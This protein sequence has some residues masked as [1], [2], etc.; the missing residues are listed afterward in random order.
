[1][2]QGM[3]IWNKIFVTVAY[4][5]AL[6]CSGCNNWLSV[7]PKAEVKYEDLFRSR[8]GFKD[9]LTGVYT[10]MCAEAA[11]GTNLTYG[12]VDAMGQ[13]Y[14]LERSRTNKFY[15]FTRWEYD[16][17]ANKQMIQESWDKMYNAIVNI[18]ILIQGLDEFSGVLK[19][20]EA[21]IYRGEALGLRAMLHFDLL[22]LFGES[23]VAGA[24]S[25]A[26][27]YMDKASTKVFPLGTTQEVLKRILTD[28]EESAKLLE[29]DP[30]HTGSEEDPF[31]GNRRFHLNYY[32]V[33]ALM[34]RVYLY[35]GDKESALKSALEVIQSGKFTWVDRNSITTTQRAERDAL[36]MSE[37][38]FMLNNTLLNDL[39]N[40]YLRPGM[41]DDQNHILIVDGDV[42]KSVYE[43]DR[44]GTLDWRNTYL[45]EMPEWFGYNTRLWQYDDMP[46][47]FRNRQPLIRM[48][49]IYL[50]AAECSPQAGEGVTFL[51]ELRNHRGLPE[52]LDLPQS[53][54]PRGLQD[55]IGKEYKKEFLG[56]GQFFFYCKRMN[57]S[58]I[59]D[60]LSDFNP[61]YYRW[62]LPDLEKEY[63]NRK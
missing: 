4:L 59:P 5:S 27:P 53:I 32:A 18:N 28:L 7:S 25:P 43:T 56:D 48:S 55:E 30:V 11:Y 6:V 38:I 45:F 19:P 57:M 1:M 20:H 63:G 16:N 61:S 21:A 40:R 15:F 34:A 8:N 46:Q 31:L 58:E 41:I 12:A 35:A 33:K 49:E 47:Q 26:I 23:M 37:N 22:R 17:S 51:N 10:S 36:F 62:P 13:Y 3:K 60:A 42:V 54:T 9:Q 39:A 50:I 29:E 44:Y 2:I 52:N 14:Y 24:N